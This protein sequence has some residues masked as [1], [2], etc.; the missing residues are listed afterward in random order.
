MNLIGILIFGNILPFWLVSLIL[1]I[2]VI[3]LWA[4]IKFTFKI[5]IFIIIFFIIL[6]C[7]DFFG[8]FEIIKNIISSFNQLSLVLNDI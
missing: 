7:L 1:I 6:F 8:V 4:I 3:I 2:G 5:L